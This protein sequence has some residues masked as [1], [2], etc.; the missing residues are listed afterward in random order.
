MPSSVLRT[1][2][3]TSETPTN[4]TAAPGNGAAVVQWT[5]PPSNNGAAVTGYTVTRL[6]SGVVV[7]NQTFASTATTQTVTGLVNGATFQFTVA[8]INARGTG[9]SSASPGAQVVIGAPKAPSTP[10]AVPGNGAATVSWVAPADNG[11]TMTQYLVTPYRAGVQQSGQLF[12]PSATSGTISGLTNGVIY[13][14]TV[15]ARNSRGQGPPSPASAAKIAARRS[16][17]RR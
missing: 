3:P 8:A 6:Q 7:A 10:T 13:T 5:A 1:A 11:A 14:F 17:R 4:V 2:P 9:P 16:H 12:A 15:A